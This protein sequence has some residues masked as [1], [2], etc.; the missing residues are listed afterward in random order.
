MRGWSACDV[1]TGGEAYNVTESRF[2]GLPKSESNL[3]H[4]VPLFADAWYIA[5]LQN[6][7]HARYRIVFGRIAAGIFY[8]GESCVRKYGRADLNLYRSSVCT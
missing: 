7:C 3:R 8:I 2:P 6:G 4:A 1:I 5:M